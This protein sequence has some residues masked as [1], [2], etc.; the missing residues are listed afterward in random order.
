MN[1]MVHEWSAFPKETQAIPEPDL[2]HRAKVTVLT[3]VGE[4]K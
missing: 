1:L 4:W 2:S 3:G